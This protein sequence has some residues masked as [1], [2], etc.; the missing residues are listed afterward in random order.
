MQAVRHEVV[1]HCAGGRE[2]PTVCADGPGAWVPRGLMTEPPPDEGPHPF[3]TSSFFDE[4]LFGYGPQD[5]GTAPVPAEPEPLPEKDAGHVETGYVETGYESDYGE[6]PPDRSG[7]APL[8]LLLIALLLLAFVVFGIFLYRHQGHGTASSDDPTKTARRF[9]A[10]IKDKNCDAARDL[11]THDVND[12]LRH[13][14]DSDTNL[15]KVRFDDVTVVD[16]NSTVARVSFRVKS[17]ASS[18]VVMMRLVKENGK[19][20]VQELVD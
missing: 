16:K 6:P 12:Q 17:A 19:W 18:Y 11:M 4:P 7:C 20:L 3:D 1:V 5:D 10:D 15:G 9:L 13:T 14:C 2:S 8:V